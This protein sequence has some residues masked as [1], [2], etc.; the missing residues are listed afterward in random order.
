MRKQRGNRKPTWHRRYERTEGRTVCRYGKKQ[1]PDGR[2]AE[3]QT[4]DSKTALVL[5]G[6]GSRGSYELGVWQALREM[7]IGID[8]VTGTSIGAINGA[9]IAQGDYETAVSLWNRIETSQVIDIPLKDSEPLNK[10]VLQT[11]QN[12]ALNFVK[13][14]GTDTGPL[15]QTLRTVIDEDKVRSSPIDYGLVT[16]EMGSGAAHELFRED[17]PHG[18]LIDYIVASAS[19]YP[20]FKPHRIDDVRYLDGAYHDNLPVKMAIKKGADH[21][22][23]VDLEA[24]GVVKKEM[25]ELIPHVTYIRCYWNLGPTLVFDLPTMRHNIRLGYLDTMKAFHV[26]E[27][28]AFTFAPGFCQQAA[29][30]FSEFMPLEEMLEKESGGFVL[31]QLFLG[32]LKKIYEE[33]RVPEAEPGGRKTAL[34]C[35]EVAGEVFGLDR[36]TVYSYESWQSCLRERVG[37]VAMPAREGSERPKLLELLIKQAKTLTSRQA[38]AVLAARLIAGASE[39]QEAPPQAAGLAVLPEAFL[40]GFYLA[41]TKLVEDNFAL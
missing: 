10:K 24:F 38:R 20:A 14:G 33:H 27:G 3:E 15:I 11:Y 13:S 31:D 8:I 16:V 17:I 35:A 7:K 1:V 22:I 41:A 26:Y 37:S 28:Y 2:G 19:I 25:L 34:V 39:Q 29:A 6:G 32:Q 12:F 23:A 18:K 5:G 4:P 21:V 30:L 9:M 36:E 40:A